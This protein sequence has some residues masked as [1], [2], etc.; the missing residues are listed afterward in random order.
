MLQHPEYTRQRISQQADRIKALIYSKRVDVDDLVVAGPVDRIDYAEAQALDGFRPAKRGDQYGPQ[1]STF[2]F[3]GRACVPCEW[4][5]G[6]V[7]LLWDSQS[8]ATL[9]VGG[10]TV[11]GLNMT[12][13]DRPDA[14]MLDACEGGE[15]LE[16]QIEMACNRKFGA[17]DETGPFSPFHLRQ[18]EIACFDREAWDLY[19]DFYVLCRLE[20]TL[21]RD[22]GPG[23]LPW[24]GLLLAE[25]NNVCNAFE[26]DDRSTWPAAR[27]VLAKLYEHRN[28]GR[29]FE[30]SAVGHAHIDTAWLWPLAETLRKCERTFSTAVAYMREYPEYRFACSQAFQYDAMRQRNPALYADM[31]RLVA[32]GQ[33]VPVGATWVEPD[34]NIP[35]GEAL[36]RQFLFGQAF[37]LREFGRRCNEFWNP[38][39]FGYNG[40]LP[41]IM[42]QCGVTRFLTQKLS[43]NRFNK[44]LHHTFTWQGIDG[45]EVMTHFPPT[46]TY[47]AMNARGEIESLRD[48]LRKF[49]DHDRSHE[50]MMLF[51]YGDGGGGPTKD[52]LEVLRRVHDLQGLPTTEQRSADEFFERL[53][54]D[55]VDRPTMVGELYFEYHRGT[56]TSQAHVKRNN[57][58]AEIMLHDVEFI[59][60]AAAHAGSAAYPA[61]EIAAMWRLLLVNQFHDILP[62]SSI[63]PVYRD[64]AEQ[65]AE[66]FQA[67][68]RLLA[69]RLGSGDVPLNTISC[70]RSEVVEQGGRLRFVTAPPYGS[71][72]EAGAPDAV[73]LTETGDGVALENGLLRAVLDRGGRL[74]SLVDKRSGREA[75]AAAANVLELYEDY[76]TAFD[77]WDVD[78]FHMETGRASAPAE[79]CRAAAR[80]PLRAEAAFE[81]AIGAASRLT[82]TVRLDAASPRLEFRCTVDWRE[83]KRFLKVAFPV[84]ARAMNATYEMQFGCVERPTHYNTPY[85]LARFET[86]MHRWFDLSEHGFGVAI[87]NDCKYGG[88][89]HGNVMRLSL[90]R[91]PKSPDPLCDMGRHAFAYAVM[92]HGGSW[93][94]A[95]VADEAARMNHPLRFGALRTDGPLFAVDDPNVSIDTV[96]VSERGDALVLRLVERHG[97]RGVAKLKFGCPVAGARLC[98]VLEDEGEPVPVADGEMAVPYGPYRIVTLAVRR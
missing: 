69:E 65:F 24:A 57:R 60:A 98:N 1:W 23:E 21:S 72:K 8:E 2:W 50:G 74:L 80:G 92:P 46:D 3:R 4:R 51:G 17:P 12:S 54:A 89:V 73:S 41:Q 32:S 20:E 62:G 84:A 78:P 53:E 10:R 15:S 64:A 38:D 70:P 35:S 7:D 14:V 39:V 55:I 90:L 36:C 75:L 11:Q 83:S 33:W 47:N 56:Y 66:L 40:Q 29:V 96:K 86:P 77:A 61:E 59:A 76:P 13:G 43:W 79:T 28:G 18:C 34:C 82:M 42:R 6:R 45:S 71:G 93:R 26:L 94:E 97:A 95:G 19:W 85:D 25:L 52:M 31:K 44:P 87:L 16:F 49:K 67:G 68:E 9:W 37:F 81:F 27:Q 30:L 58:L 22:G 48:N 91:A 5:G 88:S 63:T